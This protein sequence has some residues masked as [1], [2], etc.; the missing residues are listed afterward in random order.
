[1]NFEDLDTYHRLHIYRHLSK[2]PGVTKIFGLLDQLLSVK[3]IYKQI[4]YHK[5]YN[6]F[7]SH[8]LYLIHNS[9]V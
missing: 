4:L 3:N 2:A 1:M 6:R 9:N 8:L 5:S 7:R